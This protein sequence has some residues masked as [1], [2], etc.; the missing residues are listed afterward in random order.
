[1]TVAA[2]PSI[3]E[4]LKSQFG[5][6]SFRP[7]QEEIIQAVLKKEDVLAVLPTG[8]GKSLCFQLP[9]LMHSGVTLVVSPLIALMKDQVDSLKA[10]GI[11]G[12]F[13]NSTLTNKEM[14]QRVRSLDE[15]KTRILYV[16]PERLMTPRFLE[17]VLNWDIKLVAIDEAHCISEWGHDFRPEYRQ[18]ANLRS[19]FPSVPFMALTATATERVREDILSQLKLKEPKKVIASFNRPNL[20][21]RVLP[22]HQSTQQLLAFLKDRPKDSGIVYCLARKTCEALAETL[23]SEGISAKPYH[24]GLS[25]QERTKNQDNFLRDNTRIIC[26]TIAFGMGVHKSNVRFVVHYNLP[27]NIESYYQETGRAGRDGLS[28]DCLLLYSSGDAAK[29]KRFIEEKSKESERMIAHK[30]LKELLDYAETP[31]CRREVLLGYFGESW[32]QDNCKGCDNCLEPRERF[33]ATIPAQKF[34][35]CV[36]RIREK[37]GFQVGFHHT[38]DVLMGKET[39]KVDRWKHQSL[40]TFGIGDEF[41]KSQWI[42]LGQELL[43]DGYLT[44]TTDNFKTIGLTEKGVGALKSRTPIELTKPL[45]SLKPKKTKITD[46]S[47]DPTLFDQL[48]SLRRSLAEERN[49]P[50]YIIFSDAS[51]RHMARDLPMTLSD[52]AQISGVGEKKLEEFG[53]AFIEEIQEWSLISNH[54]GSGDR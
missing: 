18:L 8:G 37:S 32:P 25:T 51:L 47:Y 44:Q 16:A 21:Y 4:I 10:N 33:D 35:S 9:S 48:K 26:A 34:L 17:R 19:V 20:Q 46:T 41:K 45:S 24:A 31:Q 6:T 38:I 39:D 30:Q 14:E 1:M 12:T 50:A 36:F 5:Y 43:R 7:Y 42:L 23:R 27:R 52:F 40:S 53:P 11:P 49:V 2:T 13:I 54:T 28:S 3:K 15:G 29:L 22:K